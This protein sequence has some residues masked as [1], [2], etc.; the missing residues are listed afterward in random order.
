MSKTAEPRPW[1][2]KLREDK[3]FNPI[4]LAEAAGVTD[5]FIRNIENGS[6]TPRY[7]TAIRIGAALGLSESETL[8][9][10][11]SSES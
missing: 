6:R 3:G 10:F 8:M 5:T 4:Q 2:T 7:P 11:Y 1:L 9:K